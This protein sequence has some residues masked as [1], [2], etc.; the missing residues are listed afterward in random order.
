MVTLADVCE[1]LETLGIA[2]N[3]YAYKIQAAQKKSIGVFDR[4]PNITDK[5]PIGGYKNAKS[6]ELKCY[7]T[8]HWNTSGKETEEACNAIYEKLVE[9]ISSGEDIIIG[10][11]KAKVLITTPGA[12]DTGFDEKSRIY[13][14]VIWLDIHYIK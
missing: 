13:E 8:I 2:D 9:I 5:V 11:H 10:G 7:L 4:T 6:S 3:Y 1:W 14:R 12:V